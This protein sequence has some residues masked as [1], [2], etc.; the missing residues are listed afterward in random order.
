MSHFNQ[1]PTPPLSFPCSSNT[2]GTYTALITSLI[3]QERDKVAV[4]YQT[5][6]AQLEV[7]QKLQQPE[8]DTAKEEDLEVNVK[9]QSTEQDVQAELN[10]LRAQFQVLEQDRLRA[11]R[12]E[13][14]AKREVESLRGEAEKSR[15]KM[16]S[17]ELFVSEMKREKSRLETELANLK[18]SSNAE[19]ERLLDEMEKNRVEFSSRLEKVAREG[20]N[21]EAKAIERLRRESN[22][23][24]TSIR[25]KHAQS[26][27]DADAA[28]AE[29]TKEVERYAQDL[30]KVKDERWIVETERDTAARALQDEKQL[31]RQARKRLASVHSRAKAAA[32]KYHLSSQ[33]LAISIDHMRGNLNDA[34][35][36][37]AHQMDDLRC[38]LFAAQ[39]EG[40]R[41]KEVKEK[42]GNRISSLDAIIRETEAARSAA[43]QQVTDL[44]GQLSAVQQEECQAK[45]SHAE[46]VSLLNGIIHNLESERTATGQQ[47]E[48]LLCEIS[49]NRQEAKQMEENF[50]KRIFSLDAI[51]RHHEIA[52]IEHDS[53]VLRPCPKLVSLLEYLHKLAVKRPTSESSPPTP[54]I[55]PE[56]FTVHTDAVIPIISARVDHLVRWSQQLKQTLKKRDQMIASLKAST[57]VASSQAAAENTTNSKLPQVLPMVSTSSTDRGHAQ[58][59]AP[60]A[61]RELL[62]GHYPP[63]RINQPKECS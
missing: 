16:E 61:V 37:A 41:E 4:Y 46:E 15:S 2:L 28:L 3:N 25:T 6:L 32:D 58:I 33:A 48:D 52:F 62:H 12:A 50:A 7:Q 22:S 14:A 30:W 39:E 55:V 24:I 8:L 57:T 11:R 45:E 63:R 26:S 56:S 35:T 18:E 44:N 17:L 21:H 36:T 38:Q 59:L 5:K 13:E 27:R 60:K 29:S 40:A 47:M 51:L 31:V 34:Q 42:L 54:P 1:N 43:A 49:A 23:L 20:A 10:S 9:A 19:K 53:Y